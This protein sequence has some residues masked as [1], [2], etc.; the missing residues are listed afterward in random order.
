VIRERILKL[1]RPISID[2]HLRP[3]TCSG[4]FEKIEWFAAADDGYQWRQTATGD[5]TGTGE[6][7]GINR[8]GWD[9][10]HSGGIGHIESPIGWIHPTNLPD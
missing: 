1:N 6:L 8:Y 5:A 3:S 4:V 2:Q 9:G 10:Q 7:G